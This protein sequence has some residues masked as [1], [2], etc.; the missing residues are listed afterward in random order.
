[1]LKTVDVFVDESEAASMEKK[2]LN[3]AINTIQKSI[4]REVVRYKYTGE[5]LYCPC[6]FSLLEPFYKC[7]PSCAK[8]LDWGVG[9]N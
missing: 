1:M 4:G 9:C 6:C 2:A 5:L 3:L 8:K 7:C